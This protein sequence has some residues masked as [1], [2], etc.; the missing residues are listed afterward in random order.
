MELVV[1]SVNSTYSDVE[2]MLRKMAWKITKKY[3]GD[4]EEYFSAAN[5]GFAEAYASYKPDK[6]TSFSTWVYWKVLGSMQRAIPSGKIERQTVKTGLDVD[7]T[8]FADNKSFNLSMF[9]FELSE[10]AKIVVGVLLDNP[11]DLVQMKLSEETVSCMKSGLVCQ[12]REAG[13]AVSRIL[14]TFSEL[15][16]A[17]C[18]E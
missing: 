3:G 12:L 18:I 13:W 16:S 7:F 4:W 10:D 11:F 15:R 17:L 14:D 6:G 5:E 2:N 9:L 1:D 8:I